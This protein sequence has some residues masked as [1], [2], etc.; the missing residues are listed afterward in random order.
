MALN[1]IVLIVLALVIGLV[2]I[3][4]TIREKLKK[5]ASYVGTGYVAGSARKVGTYSR[6][7]VTSASRYAR[8]RFPR[9]DPEERDEYLRRERS[10][11][12][13]FHVSGELGPIT[14]LFSA[15]VNVAE[16]FTIGRYLRRK[17]RESKQPELPDRYGKPISA[18]GGSEATAPPPPLGPYGR[19]IRPKKD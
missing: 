15:I 14:A 9:M 13:D 17:E 4:M 3:G 6:N 10:R 12:E 16:Y 1:T 18:R 8:G 5:T 11:Y 7:L 19:P 2:G